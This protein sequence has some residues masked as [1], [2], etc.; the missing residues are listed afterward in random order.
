MGGGLDIFQMAA[1]NV[2]ALETRFQAL[3]TSVSPAEA[4]QV[5][6]FC[7]VAAKDGRISTNLRLS[8]LLDLLIFGKYQNIYEW[9][10]DRAAKSSKT[11]E[12]I[13]R[14]RLGAFYEKRRAFDERFDNGPSFRYGTFNVGGAGCKR[15]GEFCVVWKD[16]VSSGR[17]EVAY[18][19]S[20]SL[21][22]YLLA[23]GAMDEA[24]SWF[25]RNWSEADLS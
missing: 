3:L 13:L 2:V 6:D 4:E 20:D 7:T 16:E 24:L 23:G 19:A 22:T 14:D 11:V 21:R 25:S 12:Q 1:E 8:A 9:A 17:R 15:Y 10:A 18:L 5:S